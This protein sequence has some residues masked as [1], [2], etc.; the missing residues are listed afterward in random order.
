MKQFELP[1]FGKID[2]DNLTE[3]QEYM[4]INFQD[5]KIILMW[6]AEEI[7]ENY[8]QNAKTILEDLDIFD[9]NN[10]LLLQKEFNNSQDKT[11]LEYLEFHLEKMPEEFAEIIG[12]SSTKSEKT[13]KLLNALE[14]KTIAFH[15]DEIVPD[16]VLNKEIS[17]EVLGIYIN[18]NLEKRIAW[19]S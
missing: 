12:E 4:E 7:S 15:E 10:L 19:E 17:D 18:E 11:I 14:L 16:Y 8:F 1:Y 5:R 2:V 13:Q 3:K 6:F 9:K